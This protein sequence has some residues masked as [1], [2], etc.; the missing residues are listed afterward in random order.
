M[1]RNKSGNV[2]AQQLRKKAFRDASGPV[3]NPTGNRKA[4]RLGM[5]K[6]EEE[7]STAKS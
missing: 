1:K 6:K 5:T 4:R 2:A 3:S 7:V